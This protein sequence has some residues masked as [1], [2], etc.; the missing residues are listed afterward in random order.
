MWCNACWNYNLVAPFLSLQ[1]PPIA[2]QILLLKGTMHCS[3][4][5]PSKYRHFFQVSCGF[6]L[7]FSQHDYQSW[8]VFL[9][10][11]VSTTLHPFSVHSGLL[12]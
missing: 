2:L 11:Y 12:C 3:L 5:N 1:F 4:L 8:H 10:T 6:F 7:L 9:H